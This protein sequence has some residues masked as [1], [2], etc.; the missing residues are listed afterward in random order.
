MEEKQNNYKLCDI[1]KFE[2]YWENLPDWKTHSTGKLT[3]KK[4]KN[5]IRK[6]ISINLIIFN[7][8][9]LLI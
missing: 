3:N 9:K 6:I 7:F 8:Y 4:L 5:F 1:C 2:G